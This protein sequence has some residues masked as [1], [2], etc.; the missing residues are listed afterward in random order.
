MKIL[1]QELGWSSRSCGALDSQFYDIAVAGPQLVGEIFVIA[2]F[3]LRP[4]K[5]GHRF[6]RAPER[7]RV[8]RLLDEKEGVARWDRNKLCAV[9]QQ[10]DALIWESQARKNFMRF[11]MTLNPCSEY[12]LIRGM[13]EFA[14]SRGNFT[15]PW[16]GAYFAVILSRRYSAHARRRR[17]PNAER[18]GMV[19]I[20]QRFV[21]MKEIIA[22]IGGYAATNR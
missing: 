21:S 19:M 10:Y 14:S 18:R 1:A 20:F 12:G 9:A 13:S 11:E 7:L 2:I 22:S 6:L 4:A 15:R 17:R 8:L 5:G 16:T 3:R